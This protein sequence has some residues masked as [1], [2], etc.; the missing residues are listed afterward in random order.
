MKPPGDSSPISAFFAAQ[1]LQRGEGLF[2]W[3]FFTSLAFLTTH[4]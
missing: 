2:C 1:P 3:A 4:P